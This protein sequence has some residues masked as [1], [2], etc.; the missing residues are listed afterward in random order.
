MH[1]FTYTG[2]WLKID[3]YW[4]M[5]IFQ[6]LRAF[7]VLKIDVLSAWKIF[8]TGKKIM[9]FYVL[10][11]QYVEKYTKNYYLNFQNILIIKICV[12]SIIDAIFRKFIIDRILLESGNFQDI[13]KIQMCIQYADF[14][15]IF[16]IFWQ[17]TPMHVHE[18]FSEY[19]K[20]SDNLLGKIYLQI[21]L[22]C[23]LYY[24]V[25]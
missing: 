6:R 14:N 23:I 12:Y 20:L 5:A 8:F 1:V 22:H 2:I 10:C 25:V 11:M 13:L 17:F 3:I 18:K 16:K 19:F 9:F 21:F 15:A 24:F 7:L 4:Q